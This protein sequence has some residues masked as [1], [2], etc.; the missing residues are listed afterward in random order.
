[1]E[2]FKMKTVWAW[3]QTAFAGIGGVLGW[4]LGGADGFLYV[5]I[6]FVVIDYITGVLRAIVEKQL[7]S[8]I[9]SKG[10]AKKV[11][12]FLVVG[13]AHLADVYLLGDGSA[14]RTAVIFF[15]ISNEGVS[16]L[17]NTVAIGLPVPEQLKTILAQLHKK[18][19]EST[20]TKNEEDK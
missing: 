14:L 4:Y 18:S 15:Y 13:I 16:L 9:G 6:A 11:A 20:D 3:T 12:L 17:E 8:R 7:S 19:G 10:I 5:L 2:G 1:M